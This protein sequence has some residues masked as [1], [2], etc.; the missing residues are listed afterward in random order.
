MGWY[1]CILRQPEKV[2]EWL[3]LKFAPY[4]HTYFAENFGNQIK[5]R[6]CYLT[7]NYAPL[8]AYIQE[9][10][11]RESTLYG[12]I[13]G[14]AMEA[15]VYFQLK[16]RA[17]AFAALQEAYEA[18]EPNEI[19]MPF[20]ELGKD[21]R[22]LLANALRSSECTIPDTW[23]EMVARKAATYAKQQG[24]FIEDYKRA[25]KIGETVTLSAREKEVLND[26]YHGLSRTEIASNQGLSVNTVKLIVNSIYA[27]LYARNI[28]D[29]I[30]IAAE[31]VLI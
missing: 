7:K 17:A 5:A 28:A 14:S 3:T 25:N 21:M 13:E 26:L 23:L 6:Y 8:L 18:A 30:R 22:T 12:R 2:P 1:N 4:V 29:V 19:I 31:R 24:L 9:S 10:E 11:R 15:C 16:N 20:I 27:K